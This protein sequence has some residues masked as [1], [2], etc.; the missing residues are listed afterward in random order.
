MQKVDKK[1]QLEMKVKEIFVAVS[2]S[3]LNFCFEVCLQCIKGP[4]VK[5]QP[6]S[7]FISKIEQ[8]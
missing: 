2:Q 1:G 5:D 4:T 3:E 7:T 8:I 6:K